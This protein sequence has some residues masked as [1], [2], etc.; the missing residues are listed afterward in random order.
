MVTWRSNSMTH[1]WHFLHLFVCSSSGR[2]ISDLHLREEAWVYIPPAPRLLIL[3]KL[4]ELAHWMC[5]GCARMGVAQGGCAANSRWRWL[6]CHRNR[7]C[8]EGGTELC[9]VVAVFIFKIVCAMEMS[10]MKAVPQRG[11]AVTLVQSISSSPLA[12]ITLAKFLAEM[13]PSGKPLC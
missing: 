3:T 13:F 5:L 4:P 8:G 9:C 7:I 11:L 2:V 6:H 1:G 12:R 10:P